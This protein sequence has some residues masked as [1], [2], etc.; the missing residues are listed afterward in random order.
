MDSNT[1]FMK[2][3]QTTSLQLH[4][5]YLLHSHLLVHHL[6]HLL[7]AVRLETFLDEPEEMFVVHAGGGVDVSVH[8]PHVVEVSVRNFF[9]CR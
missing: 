6:T 1:F 9:L 3:I 4:H 8:L 2:R 7:L 5:T